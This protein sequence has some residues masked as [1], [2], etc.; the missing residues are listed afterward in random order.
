[1][2]RITTSGLIPVLKRS[3]Y[4]T[5]Q[6]LRLVLGASDGTLNYW[7]KK[8]L[9][10]KYLIQIKKGFYLP[11]YYWDLISQRPEE[12]EV[13]LEYLANVLRQPSYVSLEYVLAK[14]GLIPESSFALTSVTTKSTRTY[15]AGEF[16]FIYRGLKPALFTGFQLVNF[17]DKQVRVA[18]P[19]KALFDFLYLKEFVSADEMRI[20]LLNEGR[21]NWEALSRE[22]KG[23][24]ERQLTASASA[25]MDKI[26]T[27]LSKNKII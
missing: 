24:L 25:K 18:S 5:K 2:K 16:K 7:I 1:M 27:L 15:L 6:N 3:P 4:L 9:D 10:E 21:I 8:L 17:K 23:E 26:K 19:A 20:Y 14:N 11:R 13:Y 22:A 12:K